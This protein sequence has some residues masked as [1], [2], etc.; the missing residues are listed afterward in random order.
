MTDG[1]EELGYVIVESIRKTI[2]I[3][4]LAVK[5]YDF[6]EKPDMEQIFV[7]D[8]LMR[9]AASYGEIRGANAIKTEFPDFYDFFKLR[10]FHTDDEHAY[11]PM[12][13]IVTYK[14]GDD[15]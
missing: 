9:A 11:A 6:V 10:R 2:V 14:T 13:T 1:N 7:L 15:K 5:G 3:H 4:K 12:D 8:S